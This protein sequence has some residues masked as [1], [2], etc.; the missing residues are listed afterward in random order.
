MWRLRMMCIEL[1]KF[2]IKHR[3]FIDRTNATCLLKKSELCVANRTVMSFCYLKIT[4][5]KS[6][7]MNWSIFKRLSLSSFCISNVDIFSLF[8]Y[9]R[10]ILEIRKTETRPNN[11]S[12]ATCS[13][14]STM[15]CFWAVYFYIANEI[16][17]LTMSKK[18]QP[19]TLAIVSRPSFALDRML[20]QLCTQKVIKCSWIMK[21]FLGTKR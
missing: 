18:I 15:S 11:F 2:F 17:Q 19:T 3:S 4:R 10:E 7:R 21:A 13:M 1:L 20:R 16:N 12:I 14:H 9:R 8:S 5:S 6:D